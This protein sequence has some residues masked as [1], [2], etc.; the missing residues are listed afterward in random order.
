MSPVG[1]RSF[2]EKLPPDY[3][4]QQNAVPD[5]EPDTSAPMKRL[6]QM[7]DEAVDDAVPT[8]SSRVLLFASLASLAWLA[9]AAAV[10][11][12]IAGSAGVGALT[13][14][15]W[16]GVAGGVAAPLS[17]IWLIALVAARVWP[18]QQREMLARIE[19]AEARFALTARETRTQLESIDSVLAAVT[20]RVDGLRKVF[21]DEVE[22]FV[23]ATDAAVHRTRTLAGSLAEDR[24]AIDASSSALAESSEKARASFDSLA[25]ALPEAE[26][27]VNRIAGLLATSATDARTQLQET[28]DL[29]AAVW[30]RSE[31]AGAQAKAAT[32]SLTNVIAAISASAADAEGRLGT[33]ATAL[34][35]SGDAALAKTGEAL[36]ATRAGVEA[37]T[38]ALAAAISRT[39]LDLEDIGGRAIETIAGRITA[40][41]EHVSE[42]S[43]RISD[44]DAGSRGFLDTVERGFSVL[45]AKLGNAA[46]SSES[47]LASLSARIG[48][49]RGEIDSLSAPLGTTRGAAKEIGDSLAAVR[50]A[51]EQ[52]LASLAEG[53]PASA[54]KGLGAIDALRG[55]VTN[56][57]QNIERVSE[58]AVA[59]N[60]PI[61]AGRKAIDELLDGL[62]DQRE[63]LEA[64]VAK[65]RSEIEAAQ[66]ILSG[67]ERSAES[68]TLSATTQLIDALG[69]VREVAAQTAGTVKTAL[70]AVVEEAREALTKASREAVRQSAIEPVETQIKALEA[71]GQR[72][73]DAAQAAAERLSRQLV[74]VAETAAAIET[75]VNEADSHLDAALRKDIGR[76]SE[77]LVEALNSAS[78]DIAKGLSAEVTETAWKQYLAGER[79]VFSR[80]AVQ[81]LTNR[82]AKEVTRRYSE[83]A[84][85]RDGVRRYIHDFEA[86]LRRF[87]AD[88]DGNALSMTLLSSDLGKLYVALA[89]ATERLR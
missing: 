74:S 12:L 41:A 59:I 47:V 6:R 50:E 4:W 83:D 54:E 44:Q 76:Q 25:G 28:E 64:V 86:M 29:L 7:D 84:E 2:P 36:E 42:L 66:G 27:Q 62:E 38:A 85:F 22:G 82:D 21:A 73:A 46:N 3:T 77:L 30:T 57:S 16:A 20:M 33:Y 39:S 11:W 34:E 37:Q 9:L 40:I 81:L 60:A 8:F 71:A 69:R 10:V 17:A 78:I 58:R 63:S 13:L 51:T 65:V 18:G 67:V 88:R 43:K 89:Q 49:V 56:L 15:E 68:T 26:A 45:D 72:S 35:A 31:E 1:R 24:A 32:A 19:A 70:E 79:G 75:R 53:V 61:A 48:Q 14:T 23:S 55:S 87:N 5:A 52:A 80:R